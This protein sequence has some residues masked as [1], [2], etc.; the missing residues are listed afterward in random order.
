MVNLLFFTITA[1]I[2]IAASSIGVNVV[3]GKQEQ[4]QY[5]V[6]NYFANDI[7]IDEDAAAAEDFKPKPKPEQIFAVLVA[8]SNGWYNYRHQADVCHAYQILRR[9]GVPEANI[10]VMMYDDIANSTENPTPGII[11]NRPNGQDV[12]DGVP[13]DY[14]GE[15]VTPEVF[16]KVLQGDEQGLRGVGSGKVLK[17][18][19]NDHVFINFVDHGA[20][21]L[22]AFP[23]EELHARELES[24]LKQMHTN[25]KYSKLVFYLEACESGSMFQ[26]LLP[27]RWNIFAT[28]A[29]NSEESSFACYYDDQRQTY[30]GDV[31]SVMWMENTDQVDLET[32]TLQ[33]QFLIVR[34]ETNTSHVQEFG[35][36]RLK[37]LPVA[38]FL[39]DAPS[40]ERISYTDIELDAVETADVPI[41]IL[42]KKIKAAA[43]PEI[44]ARH[45]RQ[46][47]RLYKLR[48]LVTTQMLEIVLAVIPE[49]SAERSLIF[50]TKQTLL[51]FDCYERV[52]KYFSKNCF[53]IAKNSYVTRKMYILVNMC[54]RGFGADAVIEAMSNTCHQAHL[55]GIH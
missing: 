52:A 37:A 53:S 10:V 26:N 19:A 54:E 39:G 2:A 23:S 49:D 42:E 5:V 50:N 9:N 29:A 20:P 27:A 3:K 31:Y 34:N 40:G 44:K 35:D 55:T 33:G 28:T 51:D 18:G 24:A 11:I 4:Q 17:S 48:K 15:D 14:I 12:Y 16:L 30:L 22:V 46:L 36:M 32:E 25:G 45:Q 7:V 41:V 1:I 6:N 21:G 38:Q 47:L 13:K 8:G 43:T